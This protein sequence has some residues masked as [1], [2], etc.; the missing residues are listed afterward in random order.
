MAEKS[1]SNQ[2]KVFWVVSFALLNGSVEGAALVSWH[3][4]RCSFGGVEVSGTERRKTRNCTSERQRTPNLMAKSVALSAERR[5]GSVAGFSTEPA[6][7][8][9]GSRS[10][11]THMGEASAEKNR[12]T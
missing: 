2:S 6:E 3:S 9:N 1:G 7:S 10:L 12:V 5:R 4:Q 11:R 8:F